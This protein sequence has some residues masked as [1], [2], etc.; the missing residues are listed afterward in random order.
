M[1]NLPNAGI[2]GPVP[3][4]FDFTAQM[5]IPPDRDPGNT[6]LAQRNKANCATIIFND[7]SIM[8]TTLCQLDTARTA[9]L[10]V[11]PKLRPLWSYR[12]DEF[13][14]MVTMYNDQAYRKAIGEIPA[15]ML[16][17]IHETR[18]ALEKAA[19]S[20]KALKEKSKEASLTG[21]M[22]L[23]T[24]QIRIAGQQ[25]TPDIPAVFLRSIQARQVPPLSFFSD[26]CLRFANE[27]P[28]ELV[29]K[30]GPPPVGVTITDSTST[31]TRAL[32]VDS[33]KMLA[34]AGIWK[35]DRLTSSFTPWHFQECSRNLERALDILSEKVTDV[36]GVPTKPTFVGE[37][38]KHLDFFLKYP[39]FD[40]LFTDIFA[41]ESKF[42]HQVLSG[43]LVDFNSYCREVDSLVYAKNALREAAPGQMIFSQ[44]RPA[45][46]DPISDFSR[47]LEFLSA[48]H[49]GYRPSPPMLRHLRRRPYSL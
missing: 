15:F 44:K 49:G 14:E 42:R 9:N 26:E 35:D 18:E 24:P 47:F 34:L 17:K 45:P 36:P 28:G 16:V 21:S 39:K 27:R 22:V 13:D 11:G 29:T 33:S 48:K 25:P 6:S 32:V 41:L 46:F 38:R 2:P 30:L 12:T 1:S 5:T 37:F 23:T 8:A 4:T 10:D 7:D 40:L 19:D 20:V 43:V 31:V 3:D